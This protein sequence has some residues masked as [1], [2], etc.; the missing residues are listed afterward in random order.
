[1]K[2]PSRFF[3]RRLRPVTYQLD[4]AGLARYLGESTPEGAP[5]CRGTPKDQ[6][7]KSTARNVVVW[8]Q[9]LTIIN[10]VVKIL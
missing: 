2:L 6:I 4:V 5:E 3:I 1:M 9:E 7:R 10:D 8:W